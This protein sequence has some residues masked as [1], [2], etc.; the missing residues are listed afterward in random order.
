MFGY[1]ITPSS[2]IL[3][4][5]ATRAQKNKKLKCLQ[6][7]D[8]ITAGFGVLGA[9]LGGTKAF[10]AS[11]GPGHI[12][13]QD[14]LSM[15][16]LLRL[17]FVGIMMQRGGPST[18]TVNFSQQEVNLAIFGGN[19][20]GLRITYSAS[21]INEMRELTAKAFSDAWQYRFPAIVLGDGYL[22]KM[23]NSITIKKIKKPADSKPILTKNNQ[24]G[25]L[26]TCF[27]SEKMLAA[28]IKTAINDWRKNKI[29]IAQAE[30]FLTEDAEIL[31]IAHGLVAAAA[32]DAIKILR[33]QNYSI[34]LFRPITLNP[35]ANSPLIA[36][37][38]K[39]TKLFIIESAL[40]QLSRLIKYALAGQPVAPII[41][42]AKPS[43]GFTPEEIVKEIKKYA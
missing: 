10:T 5:W 14:A 42:I 33:A 21:S 2:E 29:H 28:E 41:E 13:L 15:A 6:T 17:P 30:E 34:G 11:A 36:L 4:I 32:K 8:E 16:E 19:G 24:A 20:N 37:S 23:Q 12:L 35:L 1:P 39:A 3:E 7:E 43:E 26:R 38:K 31:I 22:A 40:D 25:H 9:V 18:G 27:S